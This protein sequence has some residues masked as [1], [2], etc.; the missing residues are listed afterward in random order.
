MNGATLLVILATTVA[1]AAAQ[2][3]ESFDRESFLQCAR[4]HSNNYYPAAVNNLQRQ[5]RVAQGC[6]QGGVALNFATECARD[7]TLMCTVQ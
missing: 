2:D 4:V 5:A 1:I 7:L 3:G 6:N